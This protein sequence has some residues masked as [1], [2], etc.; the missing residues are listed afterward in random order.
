MTTPIYPNV[1]V[2]GAGLMGSGIAQT[3]ASTGR[4]VYLFDIHN[5]QLEK[6]KQSIQKSAQKLYEKKTISQ[7][8]HDFAQSKIIYTQD[9]EKAHHSD[10]VIEAVTE[11][12]DTKISVLKRLEEIV[13]PDCVFA[14][15][16]SSLSITKI[17]SHLK[18]PQKLIGLH[19]MN[20]VPIMKLIEVIPS[21]LTQ[22]SITEDIYLF[23]QSMEKIHVTS[24]N[25]PGF[26]I[27]RILMPMINEAFF[28]L[29][30]GIASKEDI[31][32]AMTLGTNQPMGPLALADFIGLDT[33]L[34]ILGILYEGSKDPKFRPA[35]NLIEYV[36][37]GLLG[38]KTKQGVYNY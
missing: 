6:A 20:P 13:K 12:L 23:C 5:N 36:E 28:V 15:N 31:D 17:G 21:S 33:C 24:K 7:T 29:N 32:K 9:I 10:L 38:R 37:S 14:T 19:F 8:S 1:F 11:D 35:P 4:T 25:R 26:I 27:N 3:I 34:H 2:V 22:P 30:E 16:T 18:S